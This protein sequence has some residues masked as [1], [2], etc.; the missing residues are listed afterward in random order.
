LANDETKE[1]W[2]LFVSDQ[3][4]AK[5]TVL[6]A[7]DG[8][9]LDQFS[10]AGYV[11]HL[12]PSE[13]GET[14]FAVQMDHDAVNVIKSGIALSGHG[15]HGDIEIGNPALLPVM[16]EGQRPV[17]AVV[18]G[19]EIVQ[20]FD[21]EGEARIYNEDALLEGN[22]E[23]EVVKTLAPHHGV[24]VPMGD[25]FLISAP[26]LDVE[27]K[28]GEL[29]PRLGLSVLNKNGEQVGETAPCAGLH[30]RPIRPESWLSDARRACSSHGPTVTTRPNW[31]CS[32]MTVP[33]R[34]AA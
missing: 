4:E 11:T 19:D 6:D 32:P 34:K 15:D 10:T 16:L 2:R 20:F 5:V 17:H 21:R 30:G 1:A 27:T 9:V 33:C 23:Y 8:S 26:E 7:S 29:P 25:Y 31:R 13:S 28:E 22:A 14:L 24:A 18:H 3:A 12:V